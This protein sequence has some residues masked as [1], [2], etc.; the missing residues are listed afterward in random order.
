VKALDSYVIRGVTHNIPLLRD[1]LTEENFI[2]GNITTKYLKKVYPEGFK[3]KVLRDED[4]RQLAAAAC[5]IYFRSELLYRSFTN[6]TR[7]RIQ[8]KPLK[9][10]KL[11]GEVCKKT[12]QTK[13]TKDNENFKVSFTNDNTEYDVKGDFSFTAPV[14]N[15]LVNNKSHV[16]QLLKKSPVALRLRYQGTAFDLK[17]LTEDAAEFSKHMKEKPKLDRSKVIL[18]PMP[19]L[20]K[21]V[22]CKAG[23]T[24]YEGQELCVMEAMKM[25]NNLVAESS[26]K[27]KRVAVKEGETVDEGEILI[28]LE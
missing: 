9:S 19:G 18:A 13:I 24:V 23:D 11:Q 16:M 6:Q 25:Q 1:I 21:S 14:F 27:V 12:L 20:M 8:G 10:V 2:K 5:C 26:G 3:G 17:I 15:A 28:E 22:T 4:V 7:S